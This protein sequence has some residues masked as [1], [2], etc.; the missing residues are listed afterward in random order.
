MKNIWLS[1]ALIGVAAG[2]G[3]AEHHASEADLRAGEAEENAAMSERDEIKQSF[4]LRPGATVEVA[5]IRGTVEIEATDGD[6]AHVEVVRTASSRAAL[7]QTKIVI[8]QTPNS[9]LIRSD[10]END[11]FLMHW[12]RGKSA[13]YNETV[14]LKVPATSGSADARRQRPSGSW[15][16]QWQGSSYGHQWPSHNRAS[17]GN[18]DGIGR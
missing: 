10:S 7:E 1:F 11:N 3:C 12:I 4:Y 5:G 16:S 14:K 17:D 13:R 2:A 6:R 15:S 8:E 18:S 9:L